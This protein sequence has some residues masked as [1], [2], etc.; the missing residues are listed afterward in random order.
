MS[1]FQLS[2]GFD[3]SGYQDHNS[4]PQFRRP[5]ATAVSGQNSYNREDVIR[6]NENSHQEESSGSLLN[7]RSRVS[8]TK[9]DDPPRFRSKADPSVSNTQLRQAS[10]AQR[11][12]MNTPP[13]FRYAAAILFQLEQYQVL[14]LAGDTG[15]G[16]STGVPQ[17]LRS[18]G[19]TGNLVQERVEGPTR[20]ICISM[21]HRINAISAA[22]YVASQ[23]MTS[24]AG[25]QVVG[26]EVGY[27][28]RFDCCRSDRSR[29]I[30]CTN[31]MLLQ[32]IQVDPLLSSYSVI[33]VDAAHE[34]SSRT[35]CL[36]GL[37]KK[38]R[39]YVSN[40]H[41]KALLALTHKSTV[42][43]VYALCSALFASSNSSNTNLSFRFS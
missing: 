13:I 11:Q 27:H 25:T 17:I 19:W 39:P 9:S 35:D 6:E 16:K 40:I 41:T 32:E 37:L 31:E 20:A 24:D 14:I 30:Y 1:A 21:P 3:K 5:N 22:K 28:V 12:D 18:G 10:H 34:R 23:V 2:A 29:I 36:L 43:R 8:W 26:Q 15:C 7:L 33:V 4:S 42:L 38:V